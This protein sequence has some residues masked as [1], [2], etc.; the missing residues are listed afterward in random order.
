MPQDMGGD[1][2]FRTRFIEWIHPKIYIAAETEVW[3][4][5]FYAL[6]R[7]AIP[8]ILVNGR[9]SPRSFCG[10]GWVRPF[11][12]KIFQGISWWC[13]QSPLDAQRAIGLGALPERVQ[14]VGNLKF[15]EAVEL[16]SMDPK[17]YSFW[18][19]PCLW[20]AGSTHSGEEEILLDVYQEAS[21]EIKDLRLVLAPRHVERTPEII[22]QVES[23]GL[24]PWLL[25]QSD[26][27]TFNARTVGIVDR[28]GHLRQ[29]YKLATLVFVGKSLKGKGGQNIL[30]PA[31]FGK[32]IL[33]GPHMQ[34]FESIMATFLKA[35]AIIQVR[36]AEELKQQLLGLLKDPDKRQR[37]GEAAR[38]V[39]K[40]NQGAL[41]KTMTAITHLLA[42][43]S[44]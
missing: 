41:H 5:L 11:F 20:I 19:H 39:V 9:I 43:S 25:S 22:V 8:I 24:R 14:V 38:C 12:K 2:Y 34:N 37:L 31:A 7:K 29:L 30:E 23:R 42:R 13:M 33:V 36:D 15:D 16:E 4:N 32:P 44:S 10:Y 26:Q 3:P 6:Q 35:G 40:E 17:S 27:P 21:R 18:D 1:M 28:I